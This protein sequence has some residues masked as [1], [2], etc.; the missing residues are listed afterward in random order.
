MF[1]YVRKQAG[2]QPRRGC[3]E[4][5]LTLRLIIECARHNKKKLF[6]TY[7]DF[8]KAY[9][10][11]PRGKMFS[12]LMDLGCGV[13]MLAA[14]MA[15]YKSTLSILGA[16]II[17]STIGVRQGSPTSCFLFVLFVDALIK[18]LKRCPDD[19]WLK[20]LH[21]LM[22]MDDTV[23]FATSRERMAEKLAILESYCTEFGM[24]VNESKTKFMAINGDDADRQPFALGEFVVRH[25]DRYTYLGA[26]ITAD[27]SAESA[28]KAHV[29]EKM[30][31]LNKLVIFLATNYDAPYR[32]KKKVFDACFTTAIIYSCESWLKVPLRSIEALYRTAVKALL[33]VRS[34]ATNDVCLLECGLPSAEAVIRSRQAKFLAMILT[35]RADLQDDPLMFA[36]RLMETSH[37]PM[38]KRIK[39]I[40]S[41]SNHI[42]NDIAKRQELVRSK[43]G[44][45]FVTYARLNPSLDTHR[46]YRDNHSLPDNLRMAFTRFRTSCHRLR[47]EMARWNRPVP[48]PA[49]RT[50]RCDAAAVQDEEHVFACALTAAMRQQAGFTGGCRELFEDTS[51]GNLIMLKNCLE[52]L[53]P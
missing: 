40:A 46:I 50:C 45:K 20:W 9:D 30:S 41:S 15:L 43:A 23:I 22:L 7:V 2:A 4:H 16:A 31:H 44:S 10:R 47:I 48:P 21:C 51:M 18:R 26:I 32:V 11:V 6:I 52:I 33:G 35:T 5:L 36:I 39:E 3:T 19:G 53:E 34:T 29:N 38:F 8:S 14:L 13:V 28:L 17:T 27:G 1:S 37:K 25:C 12:L 42:A 24:V 49:E